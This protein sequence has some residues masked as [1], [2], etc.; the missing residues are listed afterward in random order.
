[1]VFWQVGSAH[2]LQL[3]LNQTFGTF[4]SV[5]SYRTLNTMVGGYW[6]DQRMKLR[7]LEMSADLQDTFDFFA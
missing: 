3:S 6:N 4:S 2:N 7:A 5:T 1:M